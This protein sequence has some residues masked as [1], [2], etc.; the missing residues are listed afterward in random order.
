MR[1]LNLAKIEL[2][3]YRRPGFERIGRKN[4]FK[5]EIM[6][7]NADILGGLESRLWVKI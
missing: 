2:A 7:R 1:N 4:P 3:P 5:M 6:S